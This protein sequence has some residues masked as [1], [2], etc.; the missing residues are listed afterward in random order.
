MIPCSQKYPFLPLTYK[1]LSKC[2]I[3]L[4]TVIFTFQ[5]DKAHNLSVQCVLSSLLGDHF[6]TFEV[7]NI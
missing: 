4:W 7:A 6:R 2:R 3:H 5:Y 1:R